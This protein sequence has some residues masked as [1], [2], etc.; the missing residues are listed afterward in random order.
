MNK[1]VFG[2]MTRP[3]EPNQTLCQLQT[4]F[5]DAKLEWFGKPVTELNLQ[6]SG[7]RCNKINLFNPLDMT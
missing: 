6:S 4:L 7:S 3:P 1:E 2:Y 5:T